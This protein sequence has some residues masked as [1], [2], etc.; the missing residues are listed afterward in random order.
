MQALDETKQEFFL[1]QLFHVEEERKE[2][3]AEVDELQ[4]VRHVTTR[5]FYNYC[6]IFCTKYHR[7]TINHTY[8]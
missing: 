5:D 7:L 3:Q 8:D 6:I 4:E 1:W 2:E